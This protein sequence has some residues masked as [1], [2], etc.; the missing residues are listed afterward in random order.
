[1][2]NARIPLTQRDVAE[3]INIRHDF[4][5]HII[6]GRCACPPPLALKLEEVT[7][8]SREIWVWGTRKEK[9][10]AW[11]NFQIKSQERRDDPDFFGK[12]G[13]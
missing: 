6:H 7:G 5:N 10:I 1:M 12:N 9:Q 3:I 2:A 11:L 8:I 4:F 13:T